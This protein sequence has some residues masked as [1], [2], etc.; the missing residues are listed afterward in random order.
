MPP[1]MGRL[2]TW[3][4]VIEWSHVDSKHSRVSV[5][6]TDV[7]SECINFARSRSHHERTTYVHTSIEGFE[8]TQR[9]GL[10]TMYEVREH[11]D[12]PAGALTRL[13]GWL[14]PGG[15][16]IVS[17][18]KSV[19]PQ[20]GT[21]ECPGLYQLLPTSYRRVSRRNHPWACR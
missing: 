9:F 16:L 13:T 21:Q 12:D 8:P 6:A 15:R 3:D 11:V 2:S 19:E 7:S 14:L 5:V 18:P 20:S 1:S 10:I 4:A 17:T